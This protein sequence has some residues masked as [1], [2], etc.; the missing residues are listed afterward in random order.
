MEII[1]EKEIGTDKKIS[2]D[3]LIVKQIENYFY[4]AIIIH[5]VL[6]FQA[7]HHGY[8]LAVFNEFTQARG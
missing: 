6:Y 5:I 8:Q 3:R 7:R 4:F 1:L 2:R